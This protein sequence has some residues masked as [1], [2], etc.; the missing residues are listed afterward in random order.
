MAKENIQFGIP[1][2]LKDALGIKG[3]AKRV[4]LLFEEGNVAQASI[5][6]IVKTKDGEIENLIKEYNMIPIPSPEKEVEHE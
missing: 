2:G 5:V 1:Q 6:E 3:H 4:T